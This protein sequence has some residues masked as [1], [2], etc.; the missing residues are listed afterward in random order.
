MSRSIVAQLVRVT[1]SL[2]LRILPAIDD[3][4]PSVFPCVRLALGCLLVCIPSAD[5]AAQTGA[6]PALPAGLRVR[7]TSTAL[8]P[9]PL[10]ATVI[11]Q[12][13][14][15]LF[16]RG[17]R[18][19]DS[20]AVPAT[21]ISLLEV[22]RGFHS[23]T[24]KGLV[25]GAITGTA[26]GAVSSYATFKKPDPCTTFVGCNGSGIESRSAATA[27]GGVAGGIVG[28]LVGAAVGAVVR[29]EEWQFLAL[30]RR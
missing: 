24:I 1:R 25:I 9:S 2:S 23:R 8:Q 5:A 19:P 20:V 15:T 18:R 26:L 10:V 7:V 12:R 14:D 16:V 17:D 30:P 21:G 3:R 13:A 27:L 28:A 22:S 11:G 4:L 29:V 6:I